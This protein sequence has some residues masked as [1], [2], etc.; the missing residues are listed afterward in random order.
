[1]SITLLKKIL[2]LDPADVEALRESEELKKIL[3]THEAMQDY[4][5]RATKSFE[6]GRH[7]DGISNWVEV[8]K[9]DPENDRAINGIESNLGKIR[10]GVGGQTSETSP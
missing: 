7:L 10:E 1:M 5:N 3:E 4:A 8:L 9:L 6:D 2:D